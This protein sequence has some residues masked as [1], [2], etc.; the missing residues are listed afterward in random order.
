MRFDLRLAL[1]EIIKK[2][3]T[4]RRRGERTVL[5]DAAHL[6]QAK[7]IVHEA[8]K[9]L[10]LRGCLLNLRYHGSVKGLVLLEH[11]PNLTP[12]RL[13]LARPSWTMIQNAT[14]VA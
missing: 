10:H 5:E 6:R 8:E 7:R 9:R 11:P 13:V 4:H 3:V 1:E 14:H 2:I 12:A